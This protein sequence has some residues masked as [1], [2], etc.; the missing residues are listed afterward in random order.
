M[1]DLVTGCF[2]DCKSQLMDMLQGVI[3]AMLLGRRGG[4]GEDQAPCGVEC[5]L[6]TQMDHLAMSVADF[7]SFFKD[8]TNKELLTKA[9]DMH[10]DFKVPYEQFN[11]LRAE[12]NEL[13]QHHNLQPQ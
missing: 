12:I 1:K 11:K 13:R 7:E 4:Q 5:G 9:S 10:A 2:K 6:V 8:I 3:T